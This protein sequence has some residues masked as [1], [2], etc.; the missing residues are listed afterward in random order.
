MVWS[1]STNYATLAFVINPMNV[2][3]LRFIERVGKG[4]RTAPRDSLVAGSVEKN[5][6]GKVSVAQAMDNSGAILGPLL[7]F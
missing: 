2:L 5:E 3:V 4:V 7:A 1:F 6:T